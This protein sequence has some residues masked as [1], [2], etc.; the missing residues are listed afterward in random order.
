[1]KL[2]SLIAIITLAPVV[3]FGGAAFFAQLDLTAVTT[4]DPIINDPDVIN[5]AR[6]V[7]DAVTSKQQSWGWMLAAGL[8][9]L[10]VMGLRSKF[11]RRLLP[12]KVGGWLDN[13]IVAWTLPSLVGMAGSVL[14]ALVAGMPLMVAL[15][16][17]AKVGVAAI[18]SYVGGKKIAEARANA[19]AKAKAEI[20]SKDEAIEVLTAGH[21]GPNP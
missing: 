13:P 6:V 11:V 1:M 7:W 10:I 9:V 15:N 12:A 17:G 4:L 14:N 16:E 20:D 2:V 21:R 18:A 5:I 3:S 19:R 8:V